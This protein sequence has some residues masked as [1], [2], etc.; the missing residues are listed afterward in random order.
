MYTDSQ[1]NIYTPSGLF[2]AA[3]PTL[4]GNQ[5]KVLVLGPRGRISVS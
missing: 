3:I 5:T 1:G 4:T 2:I